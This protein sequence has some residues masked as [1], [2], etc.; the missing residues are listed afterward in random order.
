MLHSIAISAAVETPIYRQLYDQILSKILKG[1]L[2]PGTSLPSIRVVA[3]ELRISIITVK[4]TWEMLEREGCI[5]TVVG[6]G[7]FVS[8]FSGR[9]LMLKKRGMITDKLAEDL[10][11]Y[12]SLNI[13]LE[14]LT[15]II[16]Q[17]YKKI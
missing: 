16:S 6:K 13:S 7:T 2:L 3:R 17:L 11:Y 1:E 14:E 5:Y 15:A 10:R 8:D 9:D 4:K 12:K